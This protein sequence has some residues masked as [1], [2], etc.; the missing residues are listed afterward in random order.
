[1]VFLPRRLGHHTSRGVRSNG[2]DASAPGHFSPEDHEMTASIFTVC[3][4][5][6]G[7]LVSEGERIAELFSTQHWAIKGADALACERHAGTGAPAMVIVQYPGGA[8]IVA[9]RYG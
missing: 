2:I 5:Q 3:R 4:T 6:R 8:A 7:W 1:M 9:R